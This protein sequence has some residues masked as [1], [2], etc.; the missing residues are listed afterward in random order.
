MKTSVKQQAI[1]NLEKLTA[2][3][4]LISEEFSYELYDEVLALYSQI[5]KSLP[6]LKDNVTAYKDTF[7]NAGDAF[8]DEQYYYSISLFNLVQNAFRELA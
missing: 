3:I 8:D 1:F 7:W 2:K 6:L 4:E 5:E